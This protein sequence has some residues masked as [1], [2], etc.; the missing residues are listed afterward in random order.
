MSNP[1]DTEWWKIALIGLIP[2]AQLYARVEMLD[3]SLD[4]P[5]LLIP[6][7]FI[8]PFSLIFAIMMKLG[9]INKGQGGKPYDWFMFIPVAIKFIIALILASL[10]D[11]E[12]SDDDDD[13]DQEGGSSDD[14]LDGGSFFFGGSKK[15]KL[16]TDDSDDKDDDDKDDD[17]KEDNEEDKDDDKDKDDEEDDKDDEEDYN[18]EE[19]DDEEEDE[20]PNLKKVY[21]GLVI[22]LFTNGIPFIIRNQRVCGELNER[23]RQEHIA[24]GKT[25]PFVES[26]G[27]NLWGKAFVDGTFTQLAADSI[28]LIIPFVPFIGALYR[29]FKMS[30]FGKYIDNIL[31]GFGFILGYIVVNMFNGINISETCSTGFLGKNSF[32]QMA[33]F[34]V[35]MVLIFL[36]YIGKI[37]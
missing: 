37:E 27:L 19:E 3:G 30:R 33:F 18:D 32:E 8:P 21:I 25:E 34:I 13:D 22:Q 15:R 10:F 28:P 7:F 31:W 12:E 11:K 17:D 9:Y 2:G 20:K 24:S 26:G 35:I 6:I 36:R 4:H 5:W 29:L 14:S 16:D 1:K 23:K